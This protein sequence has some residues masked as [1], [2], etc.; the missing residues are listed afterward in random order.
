VAVRFVAV[1]D[2][3]VD[4]VCAALPAPGE[5]LHDS[6]TLRAGGSAVNAALAAVAAGAEATVVG[7]IGADGAGDLVLRELETAGI[8]AVLARD[9]ERPT[10]VTVTLGGGSVVASRGANE[11]LALADVPAPL[12]GDA[13][14][15]SGFALFQRGSSAA[16]RMA[17]DAF[18]G[19]WAGVDAGSPALAPAA[20]D[21][22]PAPP[23]RST[24]LLAT[25]DEAQ[26]LTAAEPEQAARQLAER[27]TVACVKL[28]DVGALAAS[29]DELERRRVAPRPG[30]AVGAGD[31]LGAAL[32]VALAEGLSLG[33][34]LEL[35]CEA[36]ARAAAA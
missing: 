2:V 20:R 27:F 24:V 18:S 1:G 17:L 36:G 13:L 34:A 14:L 19:S 6:V 3:M 22:P 21:L 4:V 30:A 11:A 33:R 35:A 28:G 10:G 8:H 9:G 25:A 26:A 5:R 7:R 32:L 15:V 29:G 23:G 16:A 31:A 12:E